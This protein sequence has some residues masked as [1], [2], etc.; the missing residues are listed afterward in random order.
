MKDSRQGRLCKNSFLPR[1]QSSFCRSR[2]H[3]Y[4]AMRRI[5]SS[6]PFVNHLRMIYRTA[7]SRNIFTIYFVCHKLLPACVNVCQKQCFACAFGKPQK[8][9]LKKRSNISKTI[10]INRA[11]ALQM[12]LITAL[13]HAYNYIGCL[14]NRLTAFP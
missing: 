8:C 7:V 9:R 12:L 3:R 1:S 4:K 2:C 6:S 13:C 14:C 5:L 10:V 11:Y